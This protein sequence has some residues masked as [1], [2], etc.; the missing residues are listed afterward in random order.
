MGKLTSEIFNESCCDGGA[1]NCH[2]SSQPCGCDP[3]LNWYCSQ[4][5]F[6]A[7]VQRLMEDWRIEGYEGE[8]HADQLEELLEKF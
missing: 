7:A 8:M 5:K 1:T 3:G 6:K 2:Q 4:H